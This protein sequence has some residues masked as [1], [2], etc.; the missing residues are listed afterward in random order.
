MKS[1]ESSEKNSFL[2]PGQRLRWLIRQVCEYGFFRG[3]CAGNIDRDGRD[4]DL[5]KYTGTDGDTGLVVCAEMVS[6]AKVMDE[7][8]DFT[9]QAAELAEKRGL[10]CVSAER[11]PDG[12]VMSATSLSPKGDFQDAEQ[13]KDDADPPKA[14]KAK[15]S[16][17]K[18][19]E[20]APS[21]NAGG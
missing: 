21:D 19:K 8:A 3:Y 5:A 14:S 7:I 2:T 20:P 4:A 18:A 10:V 15:S 13:P 12:L 6:K 1:S 17:K 11:T 9:E 16:K